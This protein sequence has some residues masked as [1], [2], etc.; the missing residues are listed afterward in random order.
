MK[1][2]FIFSILGSMF[3]LEEEMTWNWKEF[4]R[5]TPLGTLLKIVAIS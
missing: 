1:I 4:V 2:E 3:I 5:F